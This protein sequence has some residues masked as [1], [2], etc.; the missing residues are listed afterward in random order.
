MSEPLDID[1]TKMTMNPD[2]PRNGK[3]LK[4]Y[5]TWTICTNENTKFVKNL[6]EEKNYKFCH[7]YRLSTRNTDE[8]Y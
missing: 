6:F 2:R 8:H 7:T 3:S 1:N 5:K 4:D